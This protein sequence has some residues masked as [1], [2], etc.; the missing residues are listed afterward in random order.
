ML[1]DDGMLSCAEFFMGKKKGGSKLN[2][3]PASLLKTI[4]VW[5]IKARSAGASPKRRA[6]SN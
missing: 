5:K 4:A 3:E 1:R 6:A 2:F